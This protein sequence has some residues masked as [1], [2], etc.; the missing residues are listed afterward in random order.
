MDLLLPPLTE[1]PHKAQASLRPAWLRPVPWPD[2][3]VL[4]AS[5][6]YFAPFYHLPLSLADEGFIATPAERIVQGQVPYRDFFS[7]LGPGSFYLQAAVYKLGGINLFSIRLTAWLL[8]VLITWLIF[9]LSKRLMSGPA[10]FLPPLVFTMACYSRDYQISHHWWSALFFLLMV[11][12]LTPH[13]KQSGG[14]PAWSKLLLAL[15]GLLGGAAALCMQSMGTCAVLTGLTSLVV[16]E[17]WPDGRTWRDAVRRGAGQGLYFL[18]GVGVAAGLMAVYFGAR[19]ALWEWLE[20][21]LIFVFTNYAPYESVPNAYSWATLTHLISWLVREH[22]ERALLYVVGN[23]FFS[24]VGPAIAFAGTTWQLIKPERAEAAQSRLLVLYLLGGLSSLFSEL[25]APDPYHFIYAGPLMLIL[26]FY[27]C[28]CAYRQW[29]RLRWPL[30]AAAGVALIFVALVAHRTLAYAASTCVPIQCRRGTI[31]RVPE[32]ALAWRSWIEAIE[33][34]VPAGGETFFFPYQAHVYF[35]TGTRN[36]TRYDALYAGFHSP[37]Q[38][39]EAIRTLQRRRPEHIFS[40]DRIERFTFRAHLPDD[41]PDVLEMHPVE[42]LLRGPQSL[43][44]L[45][46][47][48]ARLEVWTLKK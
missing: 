1:K 29:P 30:R 38:I 10:A 6:A 17:R 22:S 9:C 2:L 26:L 33:N 16:V 23:Y 41:K 31:Y 32:D 7:E 40:F 48:V 46:K 39:E 27:S 44:R 43:Y 13:A 12:C 35:L 45:E 5:G 14:N 47:Q 20:D 28:R 36:P 3:A 25:H 11:L 24:L 15:A 8:G 34:A 4:I 37:K 21:N 42:K 18:L 19:G